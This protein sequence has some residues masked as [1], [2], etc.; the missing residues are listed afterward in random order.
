VPVSDGS[1]YKSTAVADGRPDQEA[2]KHLQSWNEPNIEVVDGDPSIVDGVRFAPTVPLYTMNSDLSTVLTEKR[3]FIHGSYRPASFPTVGFL[4]FVP[5]YAHTMIPGA[6]GAPEYR[7]MGTYL[8]KE[9][10]RLHSGNVLPADFGH[11]PIFDN[12]QNAPT[13]GPFARTDPIPWGLLVYDYFTTFDYTAGDFDPY[14]VPGRI[15]INTAPWY[16]L[17]QIPLLGPDNWGALPTADL[18]LPSSSSPAFWSASSGIMVGLDSLGFPRFPQIGLTGL[19][20]IHPS[21][22]SEGGQWYRLGPH[23]GQA[24]AAYRDRVGYVKNTTSPFAEAHWRNNAAGLEYR[25]LTPVSYDAIRGSSDVLTDPN[26]P[27]WKRGFLSVGEL[28][29]VMGMD[30]TLDYNAIQPGNYVLA[31]G[32]F[33][34]AACLLAMIDSQFLTTRSNTFTIYT[35]LTDRE[36]PSASVRTQVTVDRSNLLPR[37][38]RSVGLPHVL[39]DTGGE[40]ELIGKREVSYFN[41]QFDE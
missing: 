25:P 38:L 13:S 20:Q 24:I 39:V 6:T 19:V 10:T 3:P 21:D 11:M 34:K 16:L 7:P 23:F 28:A 35:T 37:N 14:R 32:D 33:M 22:P 8:Y 5:R 12:S 40:P 29:N 41:A 15:N 36:T 31:T 27:D 26:Q 30:G 4:H 2:V 1:N 9:W 18:P 17:A